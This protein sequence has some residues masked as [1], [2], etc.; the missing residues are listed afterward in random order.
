MEAFAFVASVGSVTELVVK[1]LSALHRLQTQL[2]D[3]PDDIRR[4]CQTMQRMK[5]V[6]DEIKALGAPGGD[7]LDDI[8]RLA[9][10]CD[11]HVIATRD[12]L[13]TLLATLD[14]L[15]DHFNRP[16]RSSKM[17][18]ARLRTV[19]SSHEIERFEK[20]LFKHQ[21]SFIFMLNVLQEKRI[22]SLHLQLGTRNDRHENMIKV[23]SLL[24]LDRNEENCIEK[25]LRQAV[26]EKLDG[27]SWSTLQERHVIEATRSAVEQTGSLFLKRAGKTRSGPKLVNVATA[28]PRE[29]YHNST[30]SVAY[31]LKC[32][33]FNFYIPL[34]FVSGKRIKSCTPSKKDQ[35]LPEQKSWC[36]DVFLYPFTF[37][38]RSALRLTLRQD[39]LSGDVK[40]T[41][42]TYSY[43]HNADLRRHLN[44]G[45]ATAIRQM[46]ASGQARPTD[47]L[48]STGNSL[49]HEIVVRHG[50]GVPNMPEL[51]QTL[52]QST[53][54]IDV[55]IVN[56]NNRTALMQ[57]CQFMLEGP[58]AFTRMQPL[59]SLL[60]QHGANLSISDNNGQSSLL[61]MFQMSQGLEY[62]TQIL[63][64][65]TELDML[66]DFESKD[67]WLISSLARSNHSFRR[68][69]EVEFCAM[70][71]PA[72]ISS[73]PR[74]RFEAVPELD[75]DTQRA[76]LKS[77][78]R[79]DRVLFMRAICS[80]GTV[81]MVKPMLDCGID[82]DETLSEQDKTHIRH[83]AFKGNLHVVVALAEAGASLEQEEW[84]LRDH[85][86][87][88][89][90]LE[91]LLE[92]WTFITQHKPIAGRQTLSPEPEL[93]ILPWILKQQ[94]HHSYNALYVAM[95]WDDDLPPVLET[96][97]RHGYGR[98]D[99]QP[100]RTDHGIRCG[101]EIIDATRNGRPYLKQLLDAGL[102]LECEDYLG[103]TAVIH[104]VSF[105]DNGVGA[106]N[107]KFETSASEN[108]DSRNRGQMV[109]RGAEH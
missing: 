50:I 64:R 76:W 6:L 108:E 9:A 46:F 3:A 89:S 69:L 14:K 15:Q 41:L 53:S 19:K 81:E 63:N 62:L 17:V 107:F 18:R 90:V 20:M 91:D 98:R 11:E 83:A 57:C 5:G 22:R 95:G 35:G 28:F 7:S 106:G 88:S 75:A 44:A 38:S 71:T 2:S 73:D 43:N 99:Q 33:M 36:L 67:L 59:A 94:N 10:S 101:S 29:D 30:G 25:E 93:W 79:V 84:F 65:F 32:R 13:Q 24:V 16:S 87:C 80:Y 39:S 58:T 85:N 100:A 74:P 12:D 54:V 56:R 27:L 105:W 109:C 96:I 86:M 82:L 102:A 26:A 52:L 78:S 55:D 49:L 21:C 61:L 72:E 97:L 31:E 60:I 104:A 8:T 47:I 92:R 48:A 68:K 77:A 51:C 70:R 23:D 42:Q 34:G 103:I 37:W 4:L 1:S 66:Q 45:N 40:F